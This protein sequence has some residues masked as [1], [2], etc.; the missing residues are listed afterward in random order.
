MKIMCIDYGSKRIGIAA[1]DPT[2]TI[3]YPLTTITNKGL[4]NNVRAITQLTRENQIQ[5]IVF[6]LPVHYNG[7]EGEAC[8]KVRELGAALLK[9][10]ELEVDYHDER[11]SSLEA[12]EHIKQNLGITNHKKVTELVDKVAASMILNNYLEKMKRS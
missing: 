2:A 1:T 10:T 8:R 5:K 7:Q 6:G 3:S 11:Y 12:E 9:E 4:V